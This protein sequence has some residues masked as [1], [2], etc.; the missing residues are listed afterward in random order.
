LPATVR[1]VDALYWS[2]DS[3]WSFALEGYGGYGS[4]KP[5]DNTNIYIP[6]G[7]WLVIDYPLPRI[8]SLRIDGVL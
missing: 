3:H 8:R 5:S 1:P 6:R 4:V 2:N 7:V